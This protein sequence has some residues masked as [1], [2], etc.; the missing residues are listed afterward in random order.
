MLRMVLD[1]NVHSDWADGNL[2]SDQLAGLNEILR[3]RHAALVVPHLCIE[4]CWPQEKLLKWKGR[5]EEAGA[6][7]YFLLSDPPR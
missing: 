3:Q 1:T 7:L 2:C 6:V 5:V 4:W